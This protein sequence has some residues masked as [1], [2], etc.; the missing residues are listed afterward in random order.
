[1]ELRVRALRPDDRRLQDRVRDGGAEE[2][3]AVQRRR[4]GREMILAHPTGDEGREREPEQEVE[5]RPHHLAV[6]PL[7]GVKHV[8][9]VVPVDADHDEAQ[10]VCQ[11]HG[12]EW[13]QRVPVR[14][15]RHLELQDHDRDQDRYHAVAEPRAL[16]ERDRRREKTD[17]WSDERPSPNEPPHDGVERS[18]TPALPGAS[19]SWSR[20][21]RG[22]P[23][24]ALALH[25]SISRATTFVASRCRGGAA[26]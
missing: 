18:T 23:R 10:D 1:C 19:G 2:Y 21:P 13:P 17:T 11:E 25:S 3:R 4:Q 5:V 9:M 24:R 8:V 14:A 7:G 6:D 16:V 12:H 15:L 22:P 20:G 26:S